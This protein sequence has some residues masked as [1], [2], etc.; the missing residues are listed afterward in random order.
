MDGIKIKKFKKRSITLYSF[1]VARRMKE[2]F[3]KFELY[4]EV[5]VSSRRNEE[6][7][8]YSVSTNTQ[9][10]ASYIRASSLTLDF[11]NQC[12]DICERLRWRADRI[13]G[14]G[15]V[16]THAC[17][18]WRERAGRAVGRFILYAKKK[19]KLK[20]NVNYLTPREQSKYAAGFGHS[21]SC[22]SHR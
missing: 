13:S 11:C 12:F 6:N 3:W 5:I 16:A 22:Y 21:C 15:K 7:A 18:L 10:T 19:K 4:F 14:G 8:E 17:K 20:L 9:T 1:H 2:Q